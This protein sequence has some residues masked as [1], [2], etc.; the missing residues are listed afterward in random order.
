M[1]LKIIKG[2]AVQALL[3]G[4]IKI[5]AHGVNCS[6]GFGSGIAK[7]IATALPQVKTAYHHKYNTEGWNLSEIQK[8]DTTEGLVLN[9]ATQKE[10]G[11]KKDI[12]YAEMWAVEHIL[13]HACRIARSTKQAIGFPLIGAGLGGLDPI[14][15]YSLMNHV[16]NKQDYNLD[17]R[18]YLI[19]NNIC[20]NFKKRGFINEEDVDCYSTVV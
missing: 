15:V 7:A 6:N 17:A 2:N 11:F 8:V 14:E 10:Y 13:V 20:N 18:L 12:P 19:D 3:D 9:C 16:F 5:L 4:D 1:N